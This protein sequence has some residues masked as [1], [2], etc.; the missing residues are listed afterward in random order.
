MASH[1]CQNSQILED[2]FVIKGRRPLTHHISSIAITT[3][4]AQAIKIN[5]LS[6]QIIKPHRT[7]ISS[8]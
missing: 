7:S 4:N 2:L 6:V 3:K 8:K 1:N 5:K